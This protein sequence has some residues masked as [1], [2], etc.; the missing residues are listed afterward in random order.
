MDCDTTGIE[1]DMSLVKYKKLVGGGFL[2]LVNNSV[3]R[4]LKNLNY[5]D[6]DIG[7]IK[8]HIKKHGSV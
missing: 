8:D 6:V 5:E 3:E 4:S 1:P 2:E 7:K